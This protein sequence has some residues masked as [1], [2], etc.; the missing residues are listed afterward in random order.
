M[1]GKKKNNRNQDDNTL[2]KI[3]LITAVTQLI[4]TVIELIT[5]LIE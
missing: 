1:S 3:L 4:K 5:K 2:K